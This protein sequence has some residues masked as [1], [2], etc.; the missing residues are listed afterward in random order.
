MFQITGA[1]GMELLCPICSLYLFFCLQI[2][3]NTIYILFQLIL[4]TQSFGKS[5]LLVPPL[6][7]FSMEIETKN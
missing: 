2:K 5:I 4:F 3:K 7:L 1:S 6:L